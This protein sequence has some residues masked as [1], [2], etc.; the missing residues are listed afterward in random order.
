[1]LNDKAAQLINDK[2]AE[3]GDRLVILGHHYQSD[4]VIEFADHKGDSLELARKIPELESAESII[5]CGVYFMAETAAILA[6]EK[7]VYIP[8][9]KAGCPMADM[10]ALED[11]ERAWE[12][13]QQLEGKVMPITYV[14]SSAAIKAFCG[15]N[16]GTV[17]TS[18]NARKVLDYAFTEADKIF[19]MPD[20]NLGRNIADELQ[21]PANQIVT[22]DPAKERGGLNDAELAQARIILWKGWCRVHWPAFTADDVAR[23]RAEHP[24]IHTIVHLE[25]DPAT[26]QA[27]DRAGSTADI[28]K[29][30]AGLKQGEKVAIG[31]EFNLVKRLAKQYAG[32]VEILPLR[33][34]FCANMAK[35]TPAKLGDTLADLD[36][37]LRRVTVDPQ[38]AEHARLALMRM[39]ELK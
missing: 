7:R 12:T 8:E 31:T 37:P 29:F 34:M 14:N 36:S 32:Q 23:L 26:I 22:W 20:K 17:C 1:M 11:V 35:I 2:R 24:G 18:G 10:A 30:V 28:I 15:R 19:F 5:F 3:L 21:I 6:P 4:E 16:G 39:L 13:V 25:A 27:C 38:T 9:P 33:K